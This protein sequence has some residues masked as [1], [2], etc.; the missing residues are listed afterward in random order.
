MTRIGIVGGS[1]QVGSLL[2]AALSTDYVVRVIDVIPPQQLDGDRMEYVHGDVTDQASIVEAVAG[3]DMV[4]HCAIVQ[5][6]QINEAPLKGYKVNVVGTQFL[7]EAASKLPEIRGL[8]LAGTWQTI[9][10]KAAGL[11]RGRFGFNPEMVE[12]RSKL[13]VLTKVAQE[14][15]LRYYSETSDKAFC[16]IRMGTL[17]GNRMSGQS[18]AGVFIE[19]AIRS[20]PLTPYRSSMHRPMLYVDERDIQKGFTNLASRILGGENVGG[21]YDLFFPLPTTILELAR[22]VKEAVARHTGGKTDP[23]IEI[24]E[25]EAITLYQPSDKEEF[26]IDIHQSLK[27]LRLER[28]RHPE[29]SIDRI[30]LSKLGRQAPGL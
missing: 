18:A 10:F 24:V 9:D 17:L 13:Y 26:R 12:D 22:T 8:I 7:C 27:A 19:N 3:L 21:I 30:V 5:V 14:A 16:V 29:E 28:L 1:G 15:V 23:P 25:D 20:N 11:S 4:I 6:P 2:R